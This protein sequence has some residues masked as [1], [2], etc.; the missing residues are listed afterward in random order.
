MPTK[1]SKYCEGIME[2]AWLFAIVAI[3]AF[4]NVYSSRIFEPDKLTLLRSLSILILAAWIVKL[5]EGG[6]IRW[7]RLQLDGSPIR[8]ILRLPLIA[9][10]TALAVVYVIST[11]F[12]VTP[13]TSFWGS[14]QRLQ[15]MYTTFSYLVIFAAMIGNLRRRAQVERLITVAILTS[16]PI[17]LY[18][19]LQRYR[20][21]PVPWGGDVSNRIAAN[22]GNS[23]FVAAFLIM[24]LPL[25][26]GR[27]VEAFRSI[28]YESRGVVVNTV[29]ATIYVF[30]MALQLI[31]IFFSGSRGPW[32]GMF[33]GI[34]FLLILWTVLLRNR[35]L[36]IGIVVTTLVLGTGLVVFNIPNGPLERFRSLRG[37][38]RLG[39]IFSAES[40]TGQVRVLIWEG[41]AKLVA[42]HKPLEFPDGTK[43]NYNFLRPLIGY[44]P[45][46]MYVAYNPFYPTELGHVE[47]RNASPDRSHNETWDALV[48]TGVLGLGV[49]LWLFGTVFYFGLKWLGLIDS[50]KKRNVFIGLFIGGGV[51]SATFFMAWRGIAYLGVGLPFGSIIGLCAYL[52]MVALFGKYEA[53]R[54]VGEIARA[55]TL[56]MLLAAIV[57]H[58]GEINFGIAIAATRTYFWAFAALLL[59][60]GFILPKHGA[61]GLEGAKESQPEPAAMHQ[62]AISKTSKSK[63]LRREREAKLVFSRKSGAAWLNDALIGGVMVALLM[64]I[65]GYD[66]ISNSNR[67]SSVS[68]T[69]INSLTRLPNKND[70]YSLGVFTLVITVWVIAVLAFV[71]ENHEAKETKSWWSAFLVTLGVSGLTALLFWYW[72]ASGLSTAIQSVKTLD[73]LETLMTSWLTN[74]YLFVFFLIICQ[75]FFLPESWP[76]KVANPSY[77][78]TVVAPV[79]LVVALVLI[80]YT[81]LR[82]IHADIVFKMADPYTKTDYWPNATRL[83]KEA[84]KLAPDEDYYYL[85]LGRSYLEQAKVEKEP[86]K[87]IVEAASDLRKAQSI[88]P[89]N[90]DHTANLARLYT[91]WAGRSTD[92][93]TR[94][95]RANQ[96]SEYYARAVVLSPNNPN[97]WIEWS[98]LYLDVFKQT[99]KGFDYLK[100]ALD[101][102]PQYSLSEGLMGDYYF[103]ISQTITDTVVR[104]QN[105]ELAEKYYTEAARVAISSE[106]QTTIGFLYSLGNVYR[107]LNKPDLAIQALEQGIKLIPKTTDLFKFEISLADL[108]YQQKDNANALIHAQ[109]ALANAADSQKKSVE[110]F[111]TKLQSNP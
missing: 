10:V 39:Q 5:L 95:E 102:D 43:D 99:E 30:I 92:T 75:A 38:G 101:L 33:A 52:A 63:R 111:I 49:Y 89:L 90:T 79:V 25:T 109:N 9:P 98:Q 84:I 94:N 64:G 42:P 12:S 21:D 23:I 72:H 61:Y 78:G 82:I 4:F 93:N 47:K 57:S 74:F 81:N 19:I 41:A 28:L 54:S 69:I 56:S 107:L 11:I 14:Y 96:A 71:S 1:L 20:I 37:I 77:I 110:E 68:K 6:R 13:R 104:S 59:L 55:L 2:A 70:A 3:P 76:V 51:A 46:S 17:S 26:I 53:P 45:E 16:L 105:L 15:G 65:L 35:K 29:R 22:L 106:T 18:G 44:G 32:L 91:W 40:R 73:Q 48:M 88:N 62:P 50:P 60:V 66:F 34:F 85:F 97:L 24:V 83:Y 8:T 86:D 7:D 108:Y 103:R 67:L 27:I 31:A 80:N 58:F 87:L 100:H 36:T